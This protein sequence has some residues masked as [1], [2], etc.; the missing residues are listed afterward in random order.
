[1]IQAFNSKNDNHR[2]ILKYEFHSYFHSKMISK[3]SFTQEYLAIEFKSNLNFHSK[4]ISQSILTQKYL[5]IVFQSNMRF[6]QNDL[7]IIFHLKMI[8]H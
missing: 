5:A 6:T 1:M 7:A 4:L 3:P 2:I 8:R